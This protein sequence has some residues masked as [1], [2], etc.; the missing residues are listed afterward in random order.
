VKVQLKIF[1]IE[2]IRGFAAIYVIIGHIVLLYN[3]QNFFPQIGFLIKTAF[4]FGHQAV[5][6]FFIVSGFSIVHN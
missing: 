3:P 4:S 6:L 1:S 5:I 2:A